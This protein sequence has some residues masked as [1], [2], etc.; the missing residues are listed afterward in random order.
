LA[1]DETEYDEEDGGGDDDNFFYDDD[2][3][4]SNISASTPV[5][6]RVGRPESP[7]W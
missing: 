4:V 7:A 1:G 3:R 5:T 2:E 6:G